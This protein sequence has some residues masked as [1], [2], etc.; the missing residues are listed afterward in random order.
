MRLDECNLNNPVRN[1]SAVIL[2]N[3]VDEIKVVQGV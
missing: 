2:D 3:L 1:R